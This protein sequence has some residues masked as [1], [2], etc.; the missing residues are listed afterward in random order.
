LTMRKR[1]KLTILI[2]KCLLNPGQSSTPVRPN[3]WSN[4]NA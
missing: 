3:F 2:E 4:V 1:D